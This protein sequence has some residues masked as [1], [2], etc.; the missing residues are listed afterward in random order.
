M[1]KKIN[2]LLA[3]VQS[4]VRGVD[5]SRQMALGAALGM[6]LGIMPKDSAFIILFTLALL[7][8]TGNLI[9]G[10][11][12]AIT[13]SWI[14]GWME[15]ATHEI[16]LSLL[17]QSNLQAYL[18][19]FQQL[20]LAPWLRLENTVV[21][22]SLVI[23]LAAALPFYQISYWFLDKYRESVIHALTRNRLAHWVLGSSDSDLQKANS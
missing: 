5:T 16:G 19:E 3:K 17:S 18:G 10:A 13:F 12:S 4:S 8:S 1:V 22:G 6:L 14:G 20:P 21:M 11:L 15:P 23:G 9:A 2:Q 7:L